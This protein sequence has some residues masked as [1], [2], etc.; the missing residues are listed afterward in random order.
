MAKENAVFGEIDAE[1][2]KWL[3]EDA[4]KQD[5]D[6]GDVES[7]A[8]AVKKDDK[9]EAKKNTEEKGKNDKEDKK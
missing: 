6:L 9:P 3:D 1:L 4:M 7:E 8:R 2:M 5:S